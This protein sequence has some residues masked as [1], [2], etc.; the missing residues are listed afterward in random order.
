MA[1]IR[2]N[3]DDLKTKAKDFDSAAD[4]F[5]QAGDDILAAAMAMPSYDGQLSGPAR[6]AGY[7]IQTQCRE[8]KAALSNNAE[9]IRKAA[10]AFEEVDN[11]AVDV[12]GQNQEML[13]AV[14]STPGVSYSS[15]DSY[16][17]YKYDEDN[18]SVIIICMYGECRRVLITSENEEAIKDFI[19]AVDGGSE[20]VPDPTD[21]TGNSVITI[22]VVG[23]RD[24]KSAFD[25]STWIAIGADV[26][27][28]FGGIS[29]LT[30]VFTA[31]GVG[32]VA[33]GL[34]LD[35][36]Q[37]KIINQAAADMAAATNNAAAAWNAIFPGETQVGDPDYSII[38]QGPGAGKPVYDPPDIP[39]TPPGSS[40][41]PSSEIPDTSHYGGPTDQSYT[42][43]D[44]TTTNEDGSEIPETG[45]YQ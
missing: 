3:T 10:Q 45:Q 8:L 13:L 38:D 34:L 6:K 26:A 5:N 21:P 7:E 39:Y 4:A 12:F 17:G 22:P 40:I 1:R 35:A 36:S 25:K 29:I 23:Y 18:P 27:I 20:T 14:G 16:L 37:Q 28:I 33:G 41:P 15:G 44:N 42:P 31:A 19:L 24:A 2:V 9:S 43:P 32:G 30:G 11:Q